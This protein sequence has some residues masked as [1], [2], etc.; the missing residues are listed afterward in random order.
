MAEIIWSLTNAGPAITEE[1]D[2]G[3]ATNG[4]STPSKEFYLRHTYLN[5]ITNASLFTRLVTGT[6][7]G[8]KNAQDDYDEI[9]GWGDETDVDDFGGLAVNMDA[10]GS[11]ATAWPSYLVPTATEAYMVATGRGDSELN[12]RV[13][14]TQTGCP[15]EGQV[16]NGG[17]PN[18]RFKV[19]FDIPNNE[20]VLGIRQVEQVLRYDYTS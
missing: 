5:P 8:A 10:L 7:G 15:T 6:Y 13:L 9:V 20:G 19:R 18:V 12:A 17:S 16:L 11:Y 1:Y 3:S 14:T 4:A 2:H